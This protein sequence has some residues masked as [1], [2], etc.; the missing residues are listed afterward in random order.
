[1]G[2]NQ[3]LSFFEEI[4]FQGL[5][6]NL[7]A[8]KTNAAE[9]TIYIGIPSPIYVV[10]STREPKFSKLIITILVHRGLFLFLSPQQTD[11]FSFYNP[12][13]LSEETHEYLF[14]V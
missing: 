11:L 4:C 10:N 13:I 1:M 8:E 9:V 7:L 2:A 14:P 5:L 12:R 6:N 3:F